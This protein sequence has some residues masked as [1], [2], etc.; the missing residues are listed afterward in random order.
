MV[1][2]ILLHVRYVY[3]PVR[4][5]IR[6]GKAGIAQVIADG[7]FITQGTAVVVYPAFG[8]IHGFHCQP[9]GR[10]VAIFYTAGVILAVLQ[11]AVVGHGF[12]AGGIMR[13]R[14]SRW[15]PAR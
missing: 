13:S 8:M 12:A 15:T 5:F 7:I 3:N 11:H 10:G 6:E 2:K 4:I 14:V 9:A 1:R